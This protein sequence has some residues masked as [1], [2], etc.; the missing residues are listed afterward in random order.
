MMTPRRYLVLIVLSILAA[1]V[2]AHAGEVCG[3]EVMTEQG[4][5]IGV[6]GFSDMEFPTE[7]KTSGENS[8]IGCPLEGDPPV[9][10][11]KGIPF[12]APPEGDL[13]WKPPR[14]AA[15]RSSALVAAEFGPECVQRGIFGD[16]D[17]DESLRDEDCLYLNIWKPEKNGVFPVMVWIHGGALTMG[18]GSGRLYWGERLVA[19]EDV[20]VVTINYRLGH[21]GFL[22][23]PALSEED[24]R[25]SS[26]NYGLL[27]QVAAL[28]WVKANIANFGGDPGNVTIFGES[29]GGWSVCN[30]LACPPAKG[31][32]H[33]AIL[34]SGGCDTVKTM[35]AG[36]EDGLDFAEKIGC[37]GAD[38]LGCMRD[39]DPEKIYA[40]LDEAAAEEGGGIEDMATL[41]FS[42]VPHVDGWALNESPIAALQSGRFNQVPFMVGSNRDEAKLFTMYVPGIRLMSR[43]TIRRLFRRFEARELLDGIEDLYPYRDYN[44]PLDA[45]I[46]AFGDAVL[47]CKC[48]EAA[49]AVSRYQPTYYYRFDYDDHRAPDMLGAAHAVEIPFVFDN[50]DAPP[51]PTLLK[52]R[53]LPKAQEMSDIMRSYWANF[54]RNGD[55]N[56]PGLMEWPAYSPDA[57]YRM[58]LDLPQ[59][60]NETDNVEKCEFWGEQELMREK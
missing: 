23:H 27:D 24:Q 51:M 44:R 47:G 46:D 3:D 33:R 32:F 59:T 21:F 8:C 22:S 18:S 26:G 55:P 6:D 40:K 15:R 2:A 43:F 9:C 38:A 28:E 48:F 49:E 7:V 57:Q 19:K 13:R 52:K 35:E 45:V 42:W 1:S 37:G 12:A 41:G 36:F 20:V 10:V 39:R 4:P 11:Y 16:D 5:V 56:D 53:H 14:P 29:A 54:A 31:L 25:G 60:V 34:Q 58:T 30:L 50:L 17:E